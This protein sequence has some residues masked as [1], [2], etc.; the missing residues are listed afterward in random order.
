MAGLRDALRPAAQRLAWQGDCRY[1]MAAGGGAVALDGGSCHAL[2]DTRLCGEWDIKLN[3]RYE[4]VRTRGSGGPVVGHCW[5]VGRG[6][7]GAVGRSVRRPRVW[8][9]QRHF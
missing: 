3:S 5:G 9:Q 7:A 6:L 8:R 2:L 1:D 4:N